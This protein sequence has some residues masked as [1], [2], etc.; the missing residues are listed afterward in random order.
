MCKKKILCILI[1]D[2]YSLNLGGAE[3]QVKLL[4]DALIETDKYKIIYL[5]NKAKK[6]FKHKKYQVKIIQDHGLLKSFFPILMI[7]RIYRELKIIRPDIIYQNVGGI[8]TGIAAFYARRHKCKF[9]WHAASD[10]DIIPQTRWSFRQIMLMGL[11]RLFLN[12]GIKNSDMIALQT[13][14]Q[15]KLLKKRFGIVC[16]NFIPIGHPL[17]SYNPDKNKPIKVIWVANIKPLKRPEVFV[18]LA[19][20]FSHRKDISFIMIGR[21]G[22]GKWFS[23]L[24]S[25]IN[26][27]ENIRYLGKIDQNEVNRH[28]NQS[29]VL[30]NTSIYEG[31]SNTFV[32]AWMRRVP[33]ISLIVDPDNIITKNKLGF[34][35]ETMEQ[36][37]SDLSKLIDNDYLREVMGNNAQ[38]YSFE[39]HGIKKMTESAIKI[40]DTLS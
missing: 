25:K 15:A 2:H 29:H 6:D 28:L 19:K 10:D 23:D 18:K 16:S 22:W 9:L 3:Y 36:L 34:K 20:R 33:V 40:L 17:P 5:C 27:M 24:L 35:S 37:I 21:P 31:F 1:P 39:N 38:K 8:H 4:I 32:Q 26:K 11:S 12:Y 7:K 30:V 14:H 13:Q